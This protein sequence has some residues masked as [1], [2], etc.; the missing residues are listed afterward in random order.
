MNLT[1]SGRQGLSWSWIRGRT[2][3]E[4]DL[5]RKFRRWPVSL[6]CAS[7]RRLAYGAVPPGEKAFV[8][9][10]GL[11]VGE[12]DPGE[13]FDPT[14][15]RFEDGLPGGCVPFHRRAEARVGRHLFDRTDFRLPCGCC[16]AYR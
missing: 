16:P 2:P 13:G 15:R 11:A 7:H 3:D 5:P 4:I 10:V 14:A 12:R 9:E 1:L 6:C 8:L